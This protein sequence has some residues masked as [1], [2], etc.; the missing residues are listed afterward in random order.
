MLKKLLTALLALSISVGG[1]SSC[2][3]GGSD[4]SGSSGSETGDSSDADNNNVSVETSFVIDGQTIDTT[5]LNMLTINGLEVSFDE[6]RYYWLF[7][8][9]Q[10]KALGYDF[11]TQSDDVLSLLKYNTINDISATYGLIS[12][13][14]DNDVDYAVDDES[15]RTAYIQ[16][17]SQFS[18][19]EEYVKFLQENHM[20]DYALQSMLTSYLAFDNA[21]AGLFGE[22]GKFFVDNE[23]VTEA[24]GSGSVARCVQILI[25]YSACTDIPED[26]KKDWDERTVESKF[27]QLQSL[28]SELSEDEKKAVNEKSLALAKEVAEKAN[29]G[30]DF[31]SLIE[32]YNYDPGMLPKDGGEYSSIT[33]YYFTKD[34]NYVK[35]FK[36]GTFALEE[37][38]VSDVVTSADY[39]YHIIKRL[40]VDMDYVKNNIEELA[41][42]YNEVNYQTKYG[43]YYDKM[44]IV[45][46]EY[47]DKLTI[48]CIS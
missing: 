38:G 35:E 43:E 20:T 22:G 24:F 14:K 32:Q 6:F 44:D 2:R 34:Y 19:E 10:L 21:Y 36:D 48:D 5:D 26:M 7:Y 18:S 39:G 12:M 45:Y 40:P 46:S 30:E 33:G 3:L 41:K 23:G 13:A 25:P 27:N 17:V 9:D 16:Q 8:K 31:Y 15:L 42:E 37:N 4:S 29:S 1:L 28:Y 11:E 47:F